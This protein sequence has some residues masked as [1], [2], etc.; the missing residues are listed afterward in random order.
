MIQEPYGDPATGLL[1]SLTDLLQALAPCCQ[2]K[3]TAIL[4]RLEVTA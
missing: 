2:Q 3:T 4:F 1:Q